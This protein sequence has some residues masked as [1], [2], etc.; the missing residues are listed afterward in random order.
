MYIMFY[1][2][3]IIYMYIM[4]NVCTMN[5][6]YMAGWHTGRLRLHGGTAPTMYIIYNVGDD[7]DDD[8]YYSNKVNYT[9]VNNS[10]KVFHC[11]CIYAMRATWPSP[12]MYILIN[13]L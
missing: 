10:I 4:F 3:F 12:T 1:I 11:T 13:I 2:I 8:V 9:K 6:I 5:M 7:D